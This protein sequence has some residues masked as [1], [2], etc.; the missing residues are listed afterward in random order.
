MFI[1]RIE[2][3]NFK[4]FRYFAIDLDALNV[5]VGPNAAGKSNFVSI[6]NFLRDIAQ[7]GLNNAISQAGSIKYLK[8]LQAKDDEDLIIKI[9]YYPTI[10]LESQ[11]VRVSEKVELA[12]DES[13][14]TYEFSLGSSKTQPGYFIKHDQLTFNYGNIIHWNLETQEHRSLG[15][16]QITFLLANGAIRQEAHLPADLSVDMLFP[17]GVVVTSEVPVTNIPSGKL[18]LELSL[19][20]LFHNL[21]NPFSDLAIY[22][23]DPKFKNNAVPLAGKGDLAEDGSNLPQLLKE[24]VSNPDDKRKF[25]N[26]L[27]VILSFVE[28][29]DVQEQIE[30]FVTF[31]LKEK[32]NPGLHLPSFLL[33]DG[34]VNSVALVYAL[35]FDEKSPIVLEEPERHI[36]PGL[37]PQLVEMLEEVA[38]R[39]GKQLFVT[40][41]NPEFVKCA[42]LEDLFFI[43]RDRENFSTVSRPAE[44]ENVKIF[45]DNE[46]GIDSLF[47]DDLLGV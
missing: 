24:I 40:T 41:H 1:T 20:N 21:F 28:D 3:H 32:H 36:H 4:S 29:M 18:F 39:R 34:T 17:F 11:I 10:R 31:S 38:V 7:D 30:E 22:D 33:S 9:T 14:A 42:Q 45:L 8:N 46:I 37:M 27:S 5:L 13:I 12:I 16:G 47:V 44:R 2:V 15:G 43:S 23:F 19:F 6:L 25:I 35:Y 26:L